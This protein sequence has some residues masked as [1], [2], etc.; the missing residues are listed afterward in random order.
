M[1]D[2][3]KIVDELQYS[4]KFQVLTDVSE[5][6]LPDLTCSHQHDHILCRTQS[7]WSA[8][9]AHLSTEPVSVSFCSGPKDFACCKS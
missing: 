4:L 7:S 5:M 3:E 6:R 2:Y 9:P 8:L 1:G